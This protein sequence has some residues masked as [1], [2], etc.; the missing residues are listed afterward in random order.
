MKTGENGTQPKCI[1]EAFADHFS[2]VVIPTNARFIF[3]NFFNIS[4]IFDSDAKQAIQ[5]LSPSN[6]VGPD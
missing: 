6:C 3:S 4:S 2:P 5:L 1:V